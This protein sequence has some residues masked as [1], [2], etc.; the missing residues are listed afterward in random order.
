VAGL[1]GLWAKGMD[2]HNGAELKRD[3]DWT[4]KGLIGVRS[5]LDRGRALAGWQAMLHTQYGPETGEDTQ[6]T[7]GEA[8]T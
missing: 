1:A 6:H 5:R 2:P 4:G 3:M 7:E 8:E